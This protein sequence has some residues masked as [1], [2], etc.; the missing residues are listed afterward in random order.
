MTH[1]ESDEGR[2]GERWLRALGR[3]REIV[4]DSGKQHLELPLHG[5][6]EIAAIIRGVSAPQHPISSS[7]ADRCRAIQLHSVGLCG[8]TA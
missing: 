8:Y 4:S 5:S 3:F 2:R 7:S 6:W 1:H